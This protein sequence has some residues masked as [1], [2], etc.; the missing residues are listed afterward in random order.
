MPFHK[1][2]LCNLGFGTWPISLAAHPNLS[3]VGSFWRR[4]VPVVDV[5]SGI[6]PL[7]F[8]FT[9]PLHPVSLVVFLILLDPP[10]Q[11]LSSLVHHLDWL[12][13]CDLV[14]LF[15]FGIGAD[16]CLPLNL[17]RLIHHRHS[18]PLGKLL[19]HHHCLLPLGCRRHE[20]WRIL[21]LNQTLPH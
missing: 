16:H 10:C 20:T 1:Y 14:S 11:T 12:I 19:G 18:L 17:W 7:C 5:F 21:E 6:Q 9:F 8:L 4:C 3:T 2:M 13:C 15:A